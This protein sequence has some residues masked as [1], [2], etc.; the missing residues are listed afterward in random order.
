MPHAAPC[1]PRPSRPHHLLLQPSA[2]M[3][4][5]ASS[6][7]KAIRR[8]QK[9]ICECSEATVSRGQ[10]RTADASHSGVA[11][12]LFSTPGGYASSV[13]S[14]GATSSSMLTQQPSRSHFPVH[15]WLSMKPSIRVSHQ[16]LSTLQGRSICACQST[17]PAAGPCWRFWPYNRYLPHETCVP[18]RN[19]H[20]RIVHTSAA[21]LQDANGPTR[22]KQSWRPAP[23][24]L[25]G[26]NRGAWLAKTGFVNS[27]FHTPAS[28]SRGAFLYSA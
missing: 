14:K 6:L 21:F 11:Q 26:P 12:L 17:L 20:L 23:A 24:S 19:W 5:A 13:Q 1:K 3:L 25:C 8:Y 15:C 9:S 22:R 16:P 10:G 7:C 28:S 18:R 27:T 2:A 4:P